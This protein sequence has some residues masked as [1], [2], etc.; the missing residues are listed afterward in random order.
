MRPPVDVWQGCWGHWQPAFI[1]EN[2]LPLGHAA[3]QG[4][5]I[6]G[7]GMVA[8][9]V[10]VV[11]ATTVDWC[12]DVVQYSLQYIPAGAVPAYLKS[13]HLSADFSHRLMNTV[14]TYTPDRDVLIAI[15]GKPIEIDWLRNLAIAPPDCYHQVCN[16][17]DEFNLEP[18][19]D[20]RCN[21]AE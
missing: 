3:W 13:H 14:Q 19:S 11:N 5:L 7:R 18:K 17:W 20:R 1:R 16:R 2:L 10:D 4:Y 21:D 15:G 6:H 12:G 8:C 9:A